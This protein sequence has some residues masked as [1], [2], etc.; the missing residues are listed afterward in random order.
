MRQ[1]K[2]ILSLVMVIILLSM[3]LIMGVGYASE[4][5]NILQIISPTSATMNILLIIKMESQ[6]LQ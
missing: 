6:L 5:G 4:T 2:I 3:I 1:E